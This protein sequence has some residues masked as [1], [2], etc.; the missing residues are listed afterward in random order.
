[1]RKSKLLGFLLMLLLPVLALTGVAG[2]QNFRS[3][4]NTT[5]SA[6]DTIDSSLFVTGRNIDIAGVVKGDVFCAGMTVTISGNV[7]GDIICAA[8]TITISGKVSGDVRVAG[9][10]V[11]V[12]GEV[13]RNLTAAGQSFSLSGNAKV[14]QDASI[15]SS[16]TTLNGTVG[17]DL[18]LGSANATLT[19]S[20]GR[21]ITATTENLSLTESARVAGDITYTSTNDAVVASGA[22][23]GGITTRK[24]PPQEP[25]GRY[26][27]L[28]AFS[29]G[30]ALYVIL[31]LFIVALTLVLLFPQVLHHTTE[32]ALRAPGKVLLI[33]LAASIIAPVLIIS[34][35]VT[36]VGVPLALLLLLV[37]LVIQALAWPFSSYALGRWVFRHQTRGSVLV[38]FVGGL[39]ILL[40]YFVPVLGFI[41]LVLVQLMGIG[42]ILS[43][44]MR[45]TPKPAYDLHKAN[46]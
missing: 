34:L 19:N 31:S 46:K 27:N 12:N 6:G 37:W 15:G 26:G 9:Q 45:R 28:F 16:D 36:V 38:I 4:D 30:V 21:N 41:S 44:L 32:R 1:M 17:R 43:E 35:M 33:G 10:T 8:Q 23:V 11:T 3:G 29:F 2:A 7:S 42:M 18:A 22:R 40:S 5:V 39:I 25:T 14:G 13:A 20:V 24:D